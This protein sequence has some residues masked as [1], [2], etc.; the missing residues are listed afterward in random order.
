MFELFSNFQIFKDRLSDCPLMEY[1]L[2]RN[3]PVLDKTCNKVFLYLLEQERNFEKSPNENK[4]EKIELLS[5]H[6]RSKSA[7]HHRDCPPIV[8]GNLDIEIVKHGKN[9]ATSSN[10]SFNHVFP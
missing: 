1:V 5:R 7:S 3:S 10:G 4:V 2:N 6:R 8:D 9:H